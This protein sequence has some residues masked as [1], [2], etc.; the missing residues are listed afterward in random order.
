MRIIYAGGGATVGE[1]WRERRGGQD[2]VAAMFFRKKRWVRDE[3]KGGGRK[4]SVAEPPKLI[5]L[6]CANHHLNGNPG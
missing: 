4:Q 6:K 1:R 2:G 3:G 5:Q